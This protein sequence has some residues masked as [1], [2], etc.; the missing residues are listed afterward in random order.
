MLPLYRLLSRLLPNDVPARKPPTAAG[1]GGR[2]APDFALP[3]DDGSVVRLRE[4][5]GRP[6][7][8]FFYPKDDSPT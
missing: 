1:L 8:V 2:M 4:L 6:V 3:A 7:V 5:R